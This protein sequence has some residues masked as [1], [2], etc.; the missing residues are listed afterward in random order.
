M[1]TIL[2]RARQTRPPLSRAPRRR[3]SPGAKKVLHD[4]LQAL[5]SDA[6]PGPLLPKLKEVIPDPEQ[7]LVDHLAAVEM[8]RE[9]RRA[10]GPK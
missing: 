1:A 10:A 8:P 2:A 4:Y 5:R 7:A 3:G 9:P 6:S